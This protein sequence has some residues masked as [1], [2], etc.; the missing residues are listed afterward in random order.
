MNA[1]LNKIKSTNQATTLLVILMLSLGTLMSCGPVNQNESAVDGE[2]AT[3]QGDVEEGAGGEAVLES[4]DSDNDS[5]MRDATQNENRGTSA[6]SDIASGANAADVNVSM[7]ADGNQA[8]V[9]TNV[10]NAPNLAET[11]A[12][13]P[14][15]TLTTGQRYR[16]NN[17]LFDTHVLQFRNGAGDVLLGQGGSAGSFAENEDVNPVISDNAVTFTLTEGLAQEL[18]DYYCAAHQGMVGEIQV[19]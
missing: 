1:I 11:D 4:N 16:F 19:Q 17:P 14:T 5:M 3:A 13:N 7:T 2:T 18:A 6:E 10:E 15:M 12:P 9:V 8:W